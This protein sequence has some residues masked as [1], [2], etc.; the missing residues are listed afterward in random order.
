MILRIDRHDTVAVVTLNRPESR[1][2]LSGE[3]ISR[4]RAAFDELGADAGVRAV[5]LTGADP[6]FCAGLDLREVAGSGANLGMVDDVNGPFSPISKPVI[7]AVNGACVTG[8]LEIALGCDLRIASERAVFSETHARVGVMPGWGL[9]IRLPKAI[10][11]ARALQMSLAGTRVD[12][13]TALDWGLVNQVVPHDRLLDAALELAHLMAEPDPHAS[14]T[15]LRMYREA[16]QLPEAEA[17]RHESATSKAWIAAM[18]RSGVPT[19]ADLKAR[20]S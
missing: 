3:L 13:Q 12:A 9:T 2:A 14:S 11:Q 16:A 1:N 4:M 7:A 19:P 8:G 17:L 15:L 20:R 5:V 10:G 18:D 6:A